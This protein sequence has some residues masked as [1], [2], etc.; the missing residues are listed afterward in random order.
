MIVVKQLHQ[1][2]EIDLELES[3][4]QAL[5]QITSQLGESEVVV[6]ARDKLN[7]EQQRLE[8][9]KRQQHSVEW[10]IDGITSKLTTTEKEL[11]SGKIGNPKELANLQQEIDGLKAR[12]NQIEEK[13]LETMEQVELA[14]RSAATLDSELKALEAAWQSQQQQ[15][16]TDSEQLQTLLSN[17][18]HKRQLLAA[19]IDPQVIEVYHDLKKQKGTAVAKVEQGICRG[20][21]ISL[22]ITEL[23]RTR[24]GNLVR[25]SSCGRILFLA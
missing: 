9:L 12:R 16:S 1:L 6:G 18:K 2:Q 8:E 19:E 5:R 7:L 4:E 10:E 25:C 3:N 21:R 11:Y 17:L 15:L 22:P 14:T 13:A 20:C 23:Q 24:S